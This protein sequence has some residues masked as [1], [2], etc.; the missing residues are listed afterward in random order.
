VLGLML[1][2][3]G[4]TEVA[5]F[6]ADPTYR[7]GQARAS[8]H[9]T[10]TD[11]AQLGAV[12]ARPH[13]IGHSGVIDAGIAAMFAFLGALE[14]RLDAAPERFVCHGLPPGLVLQDVLWIKRRVSPSLLLT[15]AAQASRI[16]TGIPIRW[17]EAS[18][19]D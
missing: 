5:R 6:G 3:F 18:A 2:A 13:A 16:A 15:S 8:A 17:A 11:T 9:V 4:R 10:E 12:A 14:T 1:P 7:F 19:P